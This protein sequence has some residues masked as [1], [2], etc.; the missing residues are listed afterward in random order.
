MF[1]CLLK[2]Y[3]PRQPH[4]VTSGLFSPFVRIRIRIL[5]ALRRPAKAVCVCAHDWHVSNGIQNCVSFWLYLYIYIFIYTKGCAFPSFFPSISHGTS[6]FQT[7]V[8]RLLEGKR[9]AAHFF[10]G[11][12][13]AQKAAV[14]RAVV[15]THRWRVHVHVLWRKRLELLLL[16]LLLR[17]TGRSQ[18]CSPTDVVSRVVRR[19]LSAVP[20]SLVSRFV[21]MGQT[22][23]LRSSKSGQAWST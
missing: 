2:A 8:G 15:H 16:L 18:I 6:S 10:F 17:S 11:I 4:R 13:V 12:H 5:H 9:S 20:Q 14:T 19:R 1:C 23:F 3:K 21:S 7:L 22:S